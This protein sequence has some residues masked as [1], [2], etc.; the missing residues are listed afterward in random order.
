MEEG[1]PPK[2]AAFKAMEEV[3][4]P[5][6][7]IVLVLSSVFILAFLGGLTGELYKQ[8]AIT[9]ATSVVISG[10]VALT[11]TPAMCA[12]ILKPKKNKEKIF[13]FRWFNSFFDSMTNAYSAG[14][15]FFL[16]RTIIVIIL[17]AI[18]IAATVRIASVVPASL[19][20]MKIRG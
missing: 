10:F 3:T 11:L 14:V 13:I 16:K 8:F 18:L 1:L 4:G 2:A 17:F 12:L 7:A 19:V 6:V 20:L 15:R 5:V 9:I